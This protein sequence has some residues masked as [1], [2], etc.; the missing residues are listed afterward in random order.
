MKRR[1]LLAG[2]AAAAIAEGCTSLSDRYGAKADAFTDLEAYSQSELPRE[3][4]TRA[5]SG[6]QAPRVAGVVPDR[7]RDL[8]AGYF[9]ASRLPRYV[10]GELSA[11][12]IVS[13]AGPGEREAGSPA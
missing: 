4:Q 1:E 9:P 13:E 8:V 2:L 12:D 5:A 3:L 11:E 6:S 10:P 7:G